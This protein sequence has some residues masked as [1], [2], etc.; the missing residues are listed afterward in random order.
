MNVWFLF[1]YFLG[2]AVGE[3]RPNLKIYLLFPK[4]FLHLLKLL[5]LIKASWDVSAYSY[6]FC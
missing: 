3:V 1:S 2:N 4:A 6:L 5:A